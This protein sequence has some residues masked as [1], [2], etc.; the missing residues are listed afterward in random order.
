MLAVIPCS[1]LSLG[2]VP[3]PPDPRSRVTR[4]Q[5]ETVYTEPSNGNTSCVSKDQGAVT[6]KW[7]P[8]FLGTERRQ[9]SPSVPRG[10]QRWGEQ[11]MCLLASLGKCELYKKSSWKNLVRL[12]YTRSLSLFYLL[13]LGSEKK[14]WWGSMR[15]QQHKH[16]EGETMMDRV[17]QHKSQFLR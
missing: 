8:S 12:F 14:H 6:V 2:Q 17:I 9:C 5:S 4:L 7:N 15:E 16:R 10:W 1:F 13:G 11:S 3:R